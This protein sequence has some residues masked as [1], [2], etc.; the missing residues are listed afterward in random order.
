ME[1]GMILKEKGFVKK[2][3][4]MNVMDKIFDG[5]ED[6]CYLKKI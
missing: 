5:N 3:D 6:V 4:K 2:G 1:G